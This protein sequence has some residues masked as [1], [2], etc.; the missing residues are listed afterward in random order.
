MNMAVSYSISLLRNCD[1]WKSMLL[2]WFNKHLNQSM[3]NK[4]LQLWIVNVKGIDVYRSAGCRFEKTSLN[5]QFLTYSI[6]FSKYSQNH[7]LIFNLFHTGWNLLEATN[8][9]S[10]EL[11]LPYT[12]CFVFSFPFDLKLGKSDKSRVN[13][14]FLK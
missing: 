5:F 14:L 13:L 9:L 7:C 4:T 8:M 1:R 12:C 6:K 10:F 11:Q 3:E 2:T